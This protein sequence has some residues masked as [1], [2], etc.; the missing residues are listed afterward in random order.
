MHLEKCIMG[1]YS[2]VQVGNYM[3]GG[4]V[5]NSWGGEYLI[6]KD[7]GKVYSHI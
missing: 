2:H 6:T 3:F 7:P 5:D 1:Y 4:Y